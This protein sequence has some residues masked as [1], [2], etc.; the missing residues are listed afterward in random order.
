MITIVSGLPRSGTSLMMQMLA[1]GGMPIL[2]DGERQPD[3]DNPRGYLEWERIK[4][5]P[6]DPACIAEAEGKA[7]KVVS[8]LLTSLPNRHEYR[9]IFMQRPLPEVL[10]SQEEMLRRRGTAKPGTGKAAIA[11]AFES[12]LREVDA[13]LGSKS[14]LKL[15]RVPYHDLLHDPEDIGRKLVQFLKIHLDAEA[16]A[17]QVDPTLYRNRGLAH[18]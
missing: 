7:V 16:M 8:R 4:H 2:S 15:L 6:R 10:A 5:L 12:H 18:P 9:V 11:A 14:Y 3:V 13:W 17:R 1:A